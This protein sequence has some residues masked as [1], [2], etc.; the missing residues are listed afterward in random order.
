MITPDLIKGITAMSEDHYVNSGTRQGTTGFGLSSKSVAVALLPDRLDIIARNGQSIEFAQRI[1][2]ELGTDPVAWISDLR[3]IGELLK[4]VVQENDLGGIPTFVVYN[5]PTQIVDLAE[6][7]IS[8]ASQAR[9]AAILSCAE[10]IPYSLDAAVTEAIVIGHDPTDDEPQTHVLLVA[11]RQDIAT[12]IVDMIEEAG[13]E[14][15]TAT[16]LQA[17]II[18]KLA[19]SALRN[20][21][22]YQG[23][24]YLGNNCSCNIL[25]IQQTMNRKRMFF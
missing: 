15:Q 19:G 4:E 14:F 6:L 16:P 3:H 22:A 17:T 23:W 11:D 24:L 7:N 10:A 8:S 18:A 1:S 9:E 2:I 25:S 5:S 20:S 21:Q 13:L 12:A